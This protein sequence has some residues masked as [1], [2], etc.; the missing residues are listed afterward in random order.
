MTVDDMIARIARHAPTIEEFALLEDIQDC[1]NHILSEQ[2]WSW[3]FTHLDPLVR[4]ESGIYQYDLPADFGSN[5]FRSAEFGHH[6]VKVGDSTSESWLHYKTPAELMSG[7]HDSTATGR[8]TDY[9]IITSKGR[10]QLL[11]WPK[12][13]SGS[14]YTV[15]GLYR[16][17]YVRLEMNSTL[18]GELWNYLFYTVLVMHAPSDTFGL[19]AAEARTWLYRNESTMGVQITPRSDTWHI[20]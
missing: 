12:P 13:D 19:R 8:P 11:V 3:S 17:A 1:Y 15:R 20:S 4:L 7:D 6:L 18:P 14:T 16:P 2:D 10:K 9:S 5:F